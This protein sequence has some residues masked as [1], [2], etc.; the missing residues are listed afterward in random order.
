MAEAQL[1]KG[2]AEGGTRGD[3]EFIETEVMQSNW[4]AT[5]PTRPRAVPRAGGYGAGKTLPTGPKGVGK[6]GVRSN[7]RRARDTIEGVTKPA[8][9]RLAR[10]GGVKRLSGLCYDSTRDALR[11]F[12]E[13]L[14]K[15]TICYTEHANRKTVTA[16]DVV[17]ALKRQGRTLYLTEGN[18]W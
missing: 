5:G 8:I 11:T 10:R 18:V 1:P 3:D 4:S 2:S 17:H 12:L 6:G 9:K 14:I 7:R 16:A 13:N 15:D